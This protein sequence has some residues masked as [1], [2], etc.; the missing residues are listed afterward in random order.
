MFREA[1]F[2]ILECAFEVDKRS[3]E[4]LPALRLNQ[5]YRSFD[6]KDLAA[7]VATICARK[8]F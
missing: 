1:G 4:A 7:S 5:R 3:L 6:P 8:P 2:E